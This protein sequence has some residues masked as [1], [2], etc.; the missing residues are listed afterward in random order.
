MVQ[1]Q[2]DWEVDTLNSSLSK[3]ERKMSGYTNNSVLPLNSSL[4]KFELEKTAK[5]ENKKE[6]FKFQSV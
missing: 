5:K 4:S 6:N 1:F 2:T 3:F